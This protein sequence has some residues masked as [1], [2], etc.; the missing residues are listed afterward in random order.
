VSSGCLSL[1][2]R[3]LG[4]Q[5]TVQPNSPFSW[6]SE[7]SSDLYL[8]LP[9]CWLLPADL[10]QGWSGVAGT[11]LEMAALAS[12]ARSTVHLLD[13]FL[14][15]RKVSETT[16]DQKSLMIAHTMSFQSLGQLRNLALGLTSRQ[17]GDL[18]GFRFPFEQS[19]QHTLSR[20]AKYIA[21]HISNLDIHML[22]Q[23][24]DPIPLARVEHGN[25]V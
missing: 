9:K 21:E 18:F 3:S 1:F 16:A 19:Q 15:A 13:F 11:L 24:L 25:P 14:Q 12:A 4:F 8:S 23:L 17:L 10:R 5:D 7:T 6:L 22:Q 2:Q 20:D